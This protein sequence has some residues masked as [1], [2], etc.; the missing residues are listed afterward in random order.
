MLADGILD[1]RR[2]DHVARLSEVDFVDAAGNR[3]SR[4]CTGRACGWTRHTPH[5]SAGEEGI[6][7]R[8]CYG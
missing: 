4:K 7:R 6:G 1:H 8:L 5:S 3:C 2:S